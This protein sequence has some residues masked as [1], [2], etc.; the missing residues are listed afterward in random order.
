MLRVQTTP[1]AVSRRDEIRVFGR[2]EGYSGMK[3]GTKRRSAAHGHF[4][5]RVH[6]GNFP[7]CIKTYVVLYCIWCLIYSQAY[8]T[9]KT[10][11]ISSSVLTPLS[12][13]FSFPPLSAS[14]ASYKHHSSPVSG[15]R[16]MFAMVSPMRLRSELR[17]PPRFV[18]FHKAGLRPMTTLPWPIAP[19][20]NIMSPPV[21]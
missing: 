8:P 17:L 19:T 21:R 11:S 18:G 3:N 13:S 15:A 2:Q 14:L 4:P 5:Q 6:R 7:A 1:R 10:I 20:T 9:L 16:H 12:A